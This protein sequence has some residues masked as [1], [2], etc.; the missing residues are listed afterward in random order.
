MK[1]IKSQPLDKKNINNKITVPII[2]EVFKNEDIKDR[3]LVM[4]IML[5][6]IIRRSEFDGKGVG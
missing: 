3:K 1:V 6:N 2:E 5:L 4:E